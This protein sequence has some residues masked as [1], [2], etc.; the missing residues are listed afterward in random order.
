MK[1]VDD[2]GGTARASRVIRAPRQAIYDAF[3]EAGALATW[4]PPRGM[5]ARLHQFEARV[6]GGYRMS[7][8]YEEPD[9]RVRGKTTAH[10][11]VVRV[12]FIELAPGERI[13]QE[14]EFDSDEAAFGGRDEIDLVLCGC[15]RR[16][17]GIGS[18]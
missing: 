15:R 12:R 16:H 17:G 18:R 9:H 1:S 3:M 2:G 10:T 6:G 4:L 13:V 7:L 8:T 5:T 11:D 14:V